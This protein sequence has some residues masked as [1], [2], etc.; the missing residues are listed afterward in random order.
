MN[1]KIIII[2]L[3]VFAIAIFGVYIK[4]QLSNVSDE[5]IHE[6]NLTLL[7]KKLENYKL[8]EIGVNLLSPGELKKRD[9]NIKKKDII[10]D[11]AVYEYNYG[12]FGVS[13]AKF[14]YAD[15]NPD[16]KALEKGLIDQLSKF[17]VKGTLKYSQENRDTDDLS[18][19][20]VKGTM[21]YK[22][23]ERVVGFRAKLI[24]NGNIFYQFIVTFDNTDDKII[25]L[26]EKVFSSIRINNE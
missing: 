2:S 11:A 13:V 18:I 5:K 12:F 17:S 14:V 22:N 24:T 7:S 10:K 1:K 16:I 20:V 25:E 23:L 15:K 21:K 8:D 26:G 19:R 6:R 4:K 9:L 3:V